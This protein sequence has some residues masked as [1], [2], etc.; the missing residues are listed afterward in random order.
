MVITGEFNKLFQSNIMCIGV[1]IATLLL[2]MK[3]FQIMFQ[4]Y[5]AGVQC[6]SGLQEREGNQNIREKKEDRT[7]TELKRE[8]AFIYYVMV[9]NFYKHLASQRSFIRGH[10]SEELLCVCLFD[11]CPVCEPD[12]SIFLC[13]CM[14]GL[15]QIPKPRM[16]TVSSVKTSSRPS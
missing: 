14:R 15:V 5:F 6:G 4:L 13:E 3:C 16:R 11:L 9:Y 12:V 10:F 8:S 1:Q 2:T 7:R